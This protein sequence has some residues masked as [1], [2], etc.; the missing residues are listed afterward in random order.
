MLT[1][2][3]KVQGIS[4][5]HILGNILRWNFEVIIKQHYKL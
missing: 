4:F 2:A 3:D 1:S 5:R